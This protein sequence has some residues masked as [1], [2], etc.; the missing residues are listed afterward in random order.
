M[1]PLPTAK[2][3]HREMGGNRR[4]WE[5]VRYARALKRAAASRAFIYGQRGAPFRNHLWAYKGVLVM[6][7]RIEEWKVEEAMAK[8]STANYFPKS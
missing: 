2:R 3:I 8:L 4:S 5:K 6:L 7:R 1:Q